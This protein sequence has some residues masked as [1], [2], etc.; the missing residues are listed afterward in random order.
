MES[1]PQNHD[2]RNNHENFHPVEVKKEID[3]FMKYT[4]VQ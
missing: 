3:E 4:H 2:F 1:Q